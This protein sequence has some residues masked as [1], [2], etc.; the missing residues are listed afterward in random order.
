MLFI[1]YNL[2]LVYIRQNIRDLLKKGLTA[3]NSADVDYC[4]TYGTLLGYYRENDVIFGDLDGDIMINGSDDNIDNLLSINWGKHN[5][6]LHKF[7]F[8]GKYIETHDRSNICL[9]RLFYK[10][11][12]FYHRFVDIYIADIDN[13]KFNIRTSDD[14][15]YKLNFNDIYPIKKITFL[16]SEC[17]IPNN[18]NKILT[19]YYGDDYMT[20]K[21]RF[22]SEKC[23]HTNWNRHYI[24][25]NKFFVEKNQLRLYNLSMNP[26]PF[27][28]K[29]IHQ[30]WKNDQLK[31]EQILVISI[32]KIQYPDWNYVLWTDDMINNFVHSK[33]SWFL[34]IWNK[35][36]PFIKKVDC[37]RYMWM[38]EYG[39]MYADLDLVC[40][41]SIEELIHWNCAYIPV[42]NTDINWR[43]DSDKASPA[44]LI[45]NPGNKVWLYMLLYIT[46]NYHKDVR[47][48][49]GPTAL[50][51]II[52]HIYDQNIILDI[53]FLSEESVGIG[54][55][56]FGKYE[57]KY[58]H[59]LETGNW[60]DNNYYI[61]RDCDDIKKVS[62]YIHQLLK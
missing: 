13:H 57:G 1:I 16:N 28:S 45:S 12:K 23:D 32:W 9:Y 37:V 43:F 21:T 18:T 62:Y 2:I 51:N 48:A 40:K 49:T 20:P 27:T 47:R 52:K 38:Y 55:T 58:S 53:A 33:Y 22:K 3:L 19:L 15:C 56:W 46:N 29:I 24:D 4:I 14:Y 11:S 36:T 59:H 31:P 7:G 42:E 8:C 10:H 41:R 61:E 25:N 35:L 60:E 17:N 26:S 34:P 30:T 6:R 39:G 5:L 50:A 44:F 54:S